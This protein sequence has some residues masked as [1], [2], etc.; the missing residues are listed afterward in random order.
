MRMSMVAGSDA[1]NNFKASFRNIH[2]KACT[3]KEG[4][5]G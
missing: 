3:T 1:L 2:A 5:G 4:H